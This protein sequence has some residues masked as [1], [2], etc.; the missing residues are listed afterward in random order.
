MADTGTKVQHE[1]GIDTKALI[2]KRRTTFTQF[3][4]A[5]IDLRLTETRI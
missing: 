1:N 5:S 3:Q 2:S 4:G